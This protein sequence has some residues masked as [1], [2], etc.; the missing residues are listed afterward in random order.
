MLPFGKLRYPQVYHTRYPDL[1]D[2]IFRRRATTRNFPI[3][4]IWDY[5]GHCFP[6]GKDRIDLREVWVKLFPLCALTPVIQA[7]PARLRNQTFLQPAEAPF[8]IVFEI[9]PS[10]HLSM[11]NQTSLLGT[12]DSTTVLKDDG[13]LNY[14]Y[15]RFET[16]ERR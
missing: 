14:M 8:G 16:I 11:E 13:G 3:G 5:I 10:L 1:K 4:V 2:L 9:D 6:I 7:F 15:D 12:T